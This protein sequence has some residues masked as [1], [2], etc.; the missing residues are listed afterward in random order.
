MQTIVGVAGVDEKRV[1]GKVAVDAGLVADDLV[2]GGIGEQQIV[3]PDRVV[4]IGAEFD[5]E[6]D[7]ITDDHVISIDLADL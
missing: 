5:L 4:R 7:A 2:V 3:F 6:T 1:D